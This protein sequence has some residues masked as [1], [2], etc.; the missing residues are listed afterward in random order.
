MPRV[1]LYG[2]LRKIPQFEVSGNRVLEVPGKL[3]RQH[4][5]WC[6]ASQWTKMTI[7]ES[8]VAASE[9]NP[10]RLNKSNMRV[11]PAKKV[12][13]KSRE[14]REHRYAVNSTSSER[15]EENWQSL[16]VGRLQY[17]WLENV[18]K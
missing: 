8:N 16:Q 14:V 13:G 18:R 12:D 3:K 17:R 11:Q 7:N 2:A 9:L 10:C 1:S 6:T 4:T 5:W 15:N